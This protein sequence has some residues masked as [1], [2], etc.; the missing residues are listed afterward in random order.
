METYDTVE[1]PEKSSPASVGGS[2]MNVGFVEH[3]TTISSAEKSQMLNL[4]QYGGLVI[5][6]LLVLLKLMKMYVPPEDPS[7]GS[8][9]LVIEV[10]VQLSVLLIALFMIHKMVT[11]MPTYSGVGYESVNVLTIVLPLFF[12]MFALDTNVSLKLNTL[13]DRLLSIVGL[14]KETFE[15][16]ELPKL[17][18]I[19]TQS[20]H[21]SV[22][23]QGESTQVPPSMTR[24]IIEPP[25]PTQRENV[26]H[27][28]YMTFADEPMAANSS[29]F[30]SL[31]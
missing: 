28:S 27:N 21:V 11:Y 20:T 17:G 26:A 6:P 14:K 19:Q 24:D 23:Q 7:K 3:M 2:L 29:T 30:G 9:E 5:L 22:A 13:F 4:L 31:Y 8:T 16:P 10:V 12:I 18:G 1:S 15:T 25:Q